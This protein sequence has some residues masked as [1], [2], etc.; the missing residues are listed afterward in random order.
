[1]GIFGTTQQ[2]ADEKALAAE[3]AK[4]EAERTRREA[5]EA[6]LA[7]ERENLANAE[8]IKEDKQKAGIGGGFFGS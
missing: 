8:K 4:Q 7:R 3:R 5:E 6:I 1:M 2:E